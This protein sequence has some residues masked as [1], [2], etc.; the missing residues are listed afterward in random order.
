MSATRDLVRLVGK[1]VAPIK[2]RV[3]LTVARGWLDSVDDATTAQT[4]QVNLLE[5][6]TAELERFQNYGFT[7]VPP[8]NCDVAAVFV[9]GN[10]A[11]GI[12]VAIEDRAHRPTGLNAKDVALYTAKGQRVYL[13]HDNDLVLLGSSPAN[14]VALANLVLT[15]LQAIQS[16]QIALK[17]D[18]LAHVHSGGTLGGGLTGP[19]NPPIFTATPHTPSSV[20]ATEVKAK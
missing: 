17:V 15:E 2:R 18:L 16:D 5:G 13:D 4:A 8:Q 6:E 11:H 14:F 12:V 19:P 3:M 9:G 7:S 20:A 1:I 10:R